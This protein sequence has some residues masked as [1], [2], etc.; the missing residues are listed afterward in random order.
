MGSQ[1]DSR[2]TNQS[3]QRPTDPSRSGIQHM[4]KRSGCRRV[5]GMVG[6]KPEDLSAGLKLMDI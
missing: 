1:E 6:R 5:D 3:N 2:K 4:E